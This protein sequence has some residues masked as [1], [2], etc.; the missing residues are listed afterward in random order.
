[1]DSKDK[2]SAKS[3]FEEYINFN[4]MRMTAER[5]GLLDAVL[6]TK[7]WFTREELAKMLKKDYSLN[8]S[9]ATLYNNIKLLKDLRIVVAH[10]FSD[11]TKYALASVPNR[12]GLIY[13]ICSQCG[14]IKELKSK[15]MVQMISNYKAKRFSIDGYSLILYGLCST[16]KVSNTKQSLKKKVGKMK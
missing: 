4:N 7:G 3:I 11:V 14:K 12:N 2:R 5:R 8:V 13:T 10:R 15:E 16:C 1:M 9:R 6:S